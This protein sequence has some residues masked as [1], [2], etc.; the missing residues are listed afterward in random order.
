MAKNASAIVLS[1]NGTNC[2]IETSHACTVAGFERVD[3]VTIWELVHGDVALDQYHLVV[4]PGGFLDG[5][6]LGSAKAQANRLLHSRVET[7]G[8]ALFDQFRRVVADGKL[9]LGICNGFQL[10]TKLG[11][12]PGHNGSYGQQTTTLTWNDAGRFEDRW[13]WLRANPDSPCVFTTD[14]DTMYLPVRH[15]EGKFVARDSEEL[16]RIIAG[17]Q[18]V[19]TYVDSTTYQPTQQYPDNPNGSQA[20]MA[21]MCDATGRVFGLMPH[22]EAYVARTNHPRWTREELPEE[23]MGLILFRNAYRYVKERL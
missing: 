8:E 13:V 11:L 18:M 16:D 20:A 9:I 15:G 6:D 17:N 12:L 22:P 1:G 14:V 10:M 19:F 21:G 3:V 5:D 7:T 23:G 2:E 4:L